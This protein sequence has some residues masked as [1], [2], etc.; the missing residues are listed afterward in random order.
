MA[1]S[2]RANLLDEVPDLA[3]CLDPVRADAA[4]S[5]MVARVVAV[6]RGDWSPAEVAAGEPGALGLL[7]LSGVLFRRV[8]VA[9]RHGLDLI[10]PGDLV[11]PLERDGDRYAMVPAEVGWQA[12]TPARLAVLDAHFTQRMC[13]Y[14]EIIDEL[15]GRIA[16]RSAAQALRLAIVQQPRLSA[17]LHFLLWH[18]ADRFGYVTTEGVVVP[19]P[20]SH[21][22]LAQLVCAQRPPVSRA[23]KALERARLAARRP[24]GTWRLG[25]KPPEGLAELAAANEPVGA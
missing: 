12:L 14:P 21:E 1:H 2:G 6:R 4:R 25:G 10:A 15:T 24:D 7:V 18:L 22:L 3:Q 13:N 5:R 20:L 19:L 23:L 11:R 16:R 8:S 17:R 9:D